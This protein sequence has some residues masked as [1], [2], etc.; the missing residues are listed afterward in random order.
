MV[1]RLGNFLSRL[2]QMRTTLWVMARRDLASRYVGTLGGPIWVVA[3]PLATVAVFWFVFAV[4]FKAHGQH[5]APFV[6]YFLAGYLPWLFF[7]EALSTG[8]NSIVANGYLVKKTIFPS[9][10]LPLVQIVSS[11]VTHAVLIAILLILLATTGTGLSPLLPQI[12]YFYFCSLCFTLGVVWLLAS[13]VV[14]N[15]DVAQVLTVVLNLWFWMTPIVWSSDIL[16]GWAKSFVVW[17]P[18]FYVVKGYR[19]TLLYHAAFWQDGLG[20]L[21][22]WILVLPCLILGAEVFRRLKPDFADAL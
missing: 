1:S 13:L 8:A 15:R 7:N 21:R 4:G 14:F 3:Q 6:L 11:S 20:A 9:E 2:Y 12:A 16:P 17:N 19:D 5:G 22:F 10:I 18:L